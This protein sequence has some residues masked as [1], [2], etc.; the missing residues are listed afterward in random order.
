MNFR[1]F[2]LSFVASL[3]LASAAGAVEHK[4]HPR[5]EDRQMSAKSYSHFEQDYRSDTGTT[6]PGT[7]NRDPLTSAN[8]S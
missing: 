1:T 4:H 2:A 6:L 5:A 8:G 7:L 3:I